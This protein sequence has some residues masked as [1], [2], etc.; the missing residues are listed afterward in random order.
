M[1]ICVYCSSSNHIDA[2]YPEVAQTLGHLLAKREHA[3]VYGGGNVGLMGILART[4][5]EDGG[6]VIGVIPEKLKA[7]EGIAY[8]VADE[9]IVTET[10]RERKKVM[11]T[12]GDGFAVLPGG[13]GTLEE[14]LE[15]LTLK[16]LDYHQRPIALINTNG[17]FDP[18]LGF[19]D[20]LYAAQFARVRPEE[21]IHVAS[22]PADALDFI[23][24]HAT[25]SPAS[26]AF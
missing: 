25:T 11:Y 4:L 20:H 24:Q 8:G 23:E 3:L 6:H 9:L 19:F 21:L 18:L 26:E 12:R 5:H 1:N 7:K 10:M 15:V 16:Q 2:V 13:Y 17:F 22:D 14:F